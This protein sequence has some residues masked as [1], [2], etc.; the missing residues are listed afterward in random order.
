MDPVTLG[1][2]LA[3]TIVQGIA[4]LRQNNLKNKVKKSDYIPSATLEAEKR[5]R[6]YADT[7]QLPGQDRIEGNIDR[8]TANTTAGVRRAANDSASVME[9]LQASD[10]AAKA[11]MGDLQKTLADFKF[12]NNQQL[13]RVL[14][15]KAQ[16]EKDNQEAYEASKSALRGSSMQNAFS[17]ANN[18][19]T[20]G[21]LLRKPGQE[22]TPGDQSMGG[23]NDALT[24]MFSLNPN[25]KPEVR[26]MKQKGFQD[27]MRK[28]LPDPTQYITNPFRTSFDPSK[29][30]PV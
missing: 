30:L 2:T 10:A 29:L 7:T 26:A 20:A 28:L 18:A 8:Q 11:V 16:Y 17:A 5:A 19:A 4:A 1:L 24:Q 23:S 13:N 21:L 27:Y 15:T 6:A 12:Q 14:D 9:S 22:T 3:P 25:E